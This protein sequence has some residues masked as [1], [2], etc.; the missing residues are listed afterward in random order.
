MINGAE[1]YFDSL[2][3]SLKYLFVAIDRHKNLKYEYNSRQELLLFITDR[4]DSPG[5][6]TR[7]GKDVAGQRLQD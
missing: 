5:Y 3:R 2:N 1:V 6:E 7:H 4:G